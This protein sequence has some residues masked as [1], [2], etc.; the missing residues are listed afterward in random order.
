MTHLQV[1]TTWV[2]VLPAAAFAV[3]PGRFD[4]HPSP[5]AEGEGNLVTSEARCCWHPEVEQCGHRAVVQFPRRVEEGPVLVAAPGRAVREIG[6]VR[7]LSCVP[8]PRQRYHQ[9]RVATG[10]ECPHTSRRKTF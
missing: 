2:E 4:G 10:P 5:S 7:D 6:L 3:G 8:P 1:V 9:S